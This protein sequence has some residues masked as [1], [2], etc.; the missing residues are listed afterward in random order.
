MCRINTSNIVAAYYPNASKRTFGIL[1]TFNH[2]PI[3]VQTK[4]V[5]VYFLS[6]S[7]A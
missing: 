7:I 6:F 4:D 5:N 2:L 1:D 3:L